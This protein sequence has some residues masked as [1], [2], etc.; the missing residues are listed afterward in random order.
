MT[1]SPPE[2][3]DWRRLVAALANPDMRRAFAELVLDPAEPDPFRHVPAKKAS[4]LAQAMVASG[5]ITVRDGGY[6][7]DAA[8]FGR[9]LDQHAPPPHTGPARFLSDGRIAQYPASMTQR[10]ELLAGIAELAF[11][12]NEVLTEREVNERLGQFTDDFAV[13]RRYLVDFGL[14]ERRKNGT[15]YSRPAPGGEHP[16][17]RVLTGA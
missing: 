15:D 9:L 12:P 1:G 17:E 4:G 16:D 14:L 7:L 6:D 3:L 2:E 13:L 8:V 10:R 5:L 11:V